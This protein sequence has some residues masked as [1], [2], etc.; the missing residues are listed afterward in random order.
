MSYLNRTADRRADVRRVLPTAKTV[1]ALGTIY[2]VDRGYSTENENT[3]QAHVARYAWGADYHKTVGDRT[4]RLLDWMRETSRVPFDAR[5]YVDTG[6]I[7][8]RVYAQH[9][10][11]GWIGKNTCVINDELDASC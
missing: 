3:G 5:T 7:Q 11:L 2:N 4:A 8:E 9:A 1:V 10:G 6:P